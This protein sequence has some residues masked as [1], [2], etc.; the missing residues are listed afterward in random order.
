M[1]VDPDTTVAGQINEDRG[2]HQLFH[3][4]NKDKLILHLLW[5][6]NPTRP[7]SK[8]CKVTICNQKKIDKCFASHPDSK[9][10]VKGTQKT[11]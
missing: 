2:S 6:R 3:I 5:I 10:W 4:E 9:S 7:S 8:G 1:N 11:F